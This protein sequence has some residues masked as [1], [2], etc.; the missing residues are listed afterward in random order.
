MNL[1]NIFYTLPIVITALVFN[2][3]GGGGSDAQFSNAENKIQIIDCNAT[4]GYT[5]MIS[6]DTLI[7]SETPTVITTYHD[8]N[9]TKKVCVNIGKAYILRK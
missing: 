5:T 9:G 3:C 7:Q 6:N 4:N 8:T 2:A 1:K